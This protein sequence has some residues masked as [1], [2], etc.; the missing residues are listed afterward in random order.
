MALKRGR[1]F[2]QVEGGAGGA[3]PEGWAQGTMWSR[4]QG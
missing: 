2:A 1:V 4:E 3:W